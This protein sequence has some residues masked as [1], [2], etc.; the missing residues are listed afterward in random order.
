MLTV[1]VENIAEGMV[2]GRD[3][4]DDNSNTLLGEGTVLGQKHK[5]ILKRRGIE[6]VI[7]REPAEKPNETLAPEAEVDE[8][9]E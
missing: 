1:M 6:K 9:A 2:L 3:V 8:N 7:V 4:L 5:D